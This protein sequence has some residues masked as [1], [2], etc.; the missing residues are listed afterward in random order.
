MKHKTFRKKKWENLWD[1]GLSKEFL[2]NTKGTVYSRK[3][4]YIGPY[5]LKLI[6]VK[7]FCSVTDPMK[8]IKRQATDWENIF[9]NCMS[10]QILAARIY[11]EISKL[12]C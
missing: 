7:R 5:Q 8:M 4:R 6:K 12:T 10:D 1:L 3:N 2:D 9:A 11:K